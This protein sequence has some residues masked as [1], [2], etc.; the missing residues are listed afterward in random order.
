M[1]I[2]CDIL[3][4]ITSYDKS[5]ADMHKLRPKSWHWIKSNIGR[6]RLKSDLNP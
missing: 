1:W 3:R 2:K 6:K 5:H 4:E